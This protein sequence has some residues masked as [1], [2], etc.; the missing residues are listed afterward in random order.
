MKFVQKIATLLLAALVLICTTGF[1]VEKFY[2]GSYL[3]SAH[4]FTSPTLCCSSTNTLEGK[5]HTESEYHQVEIDSEAP[6]L[7]KKAQTSETI[8]VI[9]PMAT[10]LLFSNFEISF[11]EYLNYKPPL[12][13]KD[14]PILVQSFLI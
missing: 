3:K 10:T 6:S 13:C 5:C 12:L 2:C 11:S 9:L 1:T 7:N 4:V 14:I 8:I